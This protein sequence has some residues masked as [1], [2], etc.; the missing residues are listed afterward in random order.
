MSTTPASVDAASNAAEHASRP[1]DPPR[2]LTRGIRRRTWG[3]V[4]V[5]PAWTLALA[6]LAVVIYNS[7]TEISRYR[8]AR[9]LVEHGIKGEARLDR[10]S[11]ETVRGKRFAPDPSLSVDLTV[12]LPGR[13]P[14]RLLNRTLP[15]NRNVIETQ[16]M[17]PIHVDPAKPERFSTGTSPSLAADLLVSA[18]LAP[19]ALLLLAYAWIVRR[20]YLRIWRLGE[21][22]LAGV[23]EVGQS[24]LAPFSQ[25]LYC[26]RRDQRNAITFS[27]LIP[28]RAGK[29]APGD[30][31][32]VIVDPRHAERAI[33]AGLYQQS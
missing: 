8:E 3:E 32:W 19:T 15:D 23:L 11:N 24:P 7:T 26:A 28:N 20:Q 10:I 17:I 27:L 29:L 6:L 30:C 12:M 33:P 1:P 16:T 5:R 22:A 14:Y 9:W 13:E 25:T 21:A 4:R 31:L 2:P 18:I